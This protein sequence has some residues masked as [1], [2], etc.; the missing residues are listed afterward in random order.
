LHIDKTSS[1]LCETI[2]SGGQLSQQVTTSQPIT[3]Q[4]Q[5]TEQGARLMIPAGQLSQLP[6]NN[7]EKCFL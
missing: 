6:G 2:F 4:I 5:Q 3:V 7:L 1:E